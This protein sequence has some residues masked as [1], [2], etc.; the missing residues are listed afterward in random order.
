MG[1]CDANVTVEEAGR[2]SLVRWKGV[3]LGEASSKSSGPGEVPQSL[4]SADSLARPT[5]RPGGASGTVP[6]TL[7]VR[8]PAGPPDIHLT[9]REQ[10]RDGG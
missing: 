2:G 3:V 7:T 5:A 1:V 10:R 9:R 6:N 8:L 4:V